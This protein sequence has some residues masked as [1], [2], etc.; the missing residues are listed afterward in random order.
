M[1]A[2]MDQHYRDSRLL[3]QRFHGRGG[4][5]KI[6][7][8]ADDANYLHNSGVLLTLRKSCASLSADS[9]RRS[10]SSAPGVSLGLSHSAAWPRK[11]LKGASRAAAF[12]MTNMKAAAVQRSRIPSRRNPHPIAAMV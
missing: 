7:P 1:L 10:P 12:S 5:N 9:F 6:V 3:A 11:A 2:C 4:F 8:G